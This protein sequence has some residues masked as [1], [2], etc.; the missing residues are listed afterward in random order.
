MP[1][2]REF[3]ASAPFPSCPNYDRKAWARCAAESKGPT[4]F[5]NV[6]GPT[7]A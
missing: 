4:L 2:E 6:A 5:W 3:N 7:V 1:F